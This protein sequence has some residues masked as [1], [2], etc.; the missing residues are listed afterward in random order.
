LCVLQL[1]AK[2]HPVMDRCNAMCLLAEFKASPY[3]F[4]HLFMH[5][6]DFLNILITMAGLRL[7]KYILLM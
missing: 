6:C 1:I 5:A 4:T 2:R 7:L 3:Y